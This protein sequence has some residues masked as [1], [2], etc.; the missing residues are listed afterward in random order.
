[1]GIGQE[2]DQTGG[3]GI[4]WNRMQRRPVSQV[5][6]DRMNNHTMEMEPR[7]LPMEE[8]RGCELL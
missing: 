5:R 6:I 1:M 4:D 7:M 8:C 3:W 2:I